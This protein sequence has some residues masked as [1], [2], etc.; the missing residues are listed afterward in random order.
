MARRC[1]RSGRRLP[2]MPTR[3]TAARAEVL[4]VPGWMACALNGKAAM[5][6]GPR[7]GAEARRCVLAITSRCAGVGWKFRKGVA[8]RRVG[9]GRRAL[10]TFFFFCVECRRMKS[11]VLRCCSTFLAAQP[12]SVYMAGVICA[13]VATAAAC[14]QSIDKD[15][16]PWVDT[17]HGRCHL[18]WPDDTYPWVRRGRSPA[19]APESYIGDDIQHCQYHCDDGSF[20]EFFTG[21]YPYG[22]VVPCP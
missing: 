19:S 22:R 17:G 2:S 7:S 9:Q 3:Q 11:Q 6:L 13:S 21:A 18:L 1:L 16:R 4:D 5:C 10:D 14:W 8:D 12:R 15:C 20:Q